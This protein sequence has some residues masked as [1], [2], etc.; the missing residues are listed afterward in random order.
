MVWFKIWGSENGGGRQGW[1]VVVECARGSRGSLLVL[2]LM[3]IM[4]D[5]EAPHYI[6]CSYLLLLFHRN[7]TLQ[8][9]N[10]NTLYNA[11]FHFVLF[12]FLGETDLTYMEFQLDS[13]EYCQ[14]QHK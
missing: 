5:Y 2:L 3:M 12:Q 13:G 4:K 10:S 1:T 8:K 11:N 9:E 6:I 7:G 14:A